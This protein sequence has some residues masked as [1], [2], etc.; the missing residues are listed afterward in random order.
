MTHDERGGTLDVTDLG[1]HE[2]T[3]GIPLTGV[4]AGAARAHHLQRINE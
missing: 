2:R 4:H 3:T 1:H